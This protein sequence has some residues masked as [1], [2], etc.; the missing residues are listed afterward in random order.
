MNIKVKKLNKYARINKPAHI[1]DA[2]F[3]VFST[4]RIVLNP[5]QRYAM[6]LG[7]AIQMPYD[8]VCLVEQKSGLAKKYGI[9]TIG[10][11]I[12]ASYRGE[13]HAIIVNTGLGKVIIEDNQKVAQLRFVP[14]IIP[15]LVFV[16]ELDDSSRG[17]DGFGSTGL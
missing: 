12:D 11:V 4:E 13:I 3:D 9:D 16:D 2:G 14:V 10:N 17:E 15:E 7:I 6:P 1:G 5:G 8:M